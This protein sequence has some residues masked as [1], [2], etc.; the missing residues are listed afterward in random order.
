MWRIPLFKTYWDEE[1]INA[2]SNV[3]KRGTYWATGPE[4]DEFEKNI[5]EFLGMKHA[6]VFNSGTSALHAALLAYGINS[7]DEV[8]VPSFTFAATANVVSLVGAKPVFAEV[9]DESYG[10]DSEN[11]KEKITNKTKVILPIHYGGAPC[12]EIKVLKEIAQDNKLLLIEDAAESL[13]SKIENENVGTFGDSSMFSFCQNKVIS[14][15]EG[16]VIVTNSDKLHQKLKLIRSHGRLEKDSEYFST[17][18]SMDYIQA[19]YNFRMPTICAA[20]GIA[21]LNK[22]ETLVTMRRNNAEHFNNNLSHINGLKVPTATKGHYHVYQMYTIQLDSPEQRAG[23][24]NH[25]TKKGIMTKVYF[26]PLH[27][28]TFYRNT[29]NYKTGDLPKTE[30]LSKKVLTLPMY[31]GLKKDEIE[32]ITI[33]ISNFFSKGK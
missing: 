22:I 15:G 33:E 28:M 5:T 27:L 13:G 23:L 20:L 30:A 9:E 6:I 7:A 26:D 1:D 19:G 25:L 12:K 4:I 16:G 10:L 29:Y 2:I 14:T 17:S 8:I 18:K 24:Q 21:Q 3:I 11:V 31:P 32:Y